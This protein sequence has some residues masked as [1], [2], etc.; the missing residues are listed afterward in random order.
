MFKVNS[1][2]T[3][4]LCILYYVLKCQTSKIHVFITDQFAILKRNKSMIFGKT[5]FSSWKSHFLPMPA[6]QCFW[7]VTWSIT[8]QSPFFYQ[9]GFIRLHGKRSKHE[10]FKLLNWNRIGFNIR[11]HSFMMSAS[12]VNVCVV[13]TQVLDEYN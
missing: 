2:D 8:Y 9:G 6:Y 7:S 12:R 4:N 5:F 10:G 1:K 13:K 3:S 11:I